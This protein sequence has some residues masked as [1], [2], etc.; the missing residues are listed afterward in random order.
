MT[1]KL[2]RVKTKKPGRSFSNKQQTSSLFEQGFA[3]Y[4]AGRLKEAEDCC[5]AALAS[6]QHH[7]DA[8]HLLG[9][10]CQQT[11]DDL[12]AII[13]IKKAISITPEKFFYHLNLGNIYFSQ[14]N[15]VKAEVCYQKALEL[16][17]N[18]IPTMIHL[19]ENLEH[20]QRNQEAIDYYQKALTIEQNNSLALSGLGNA[21]LDTGMIEDSIA[22]FRKLVKTAPDSADSYYNLGNALMRFG[23]M[24]EAAANYRKSLQLHPGF[25]NAYFNLGLALEA[26]S[27]PNQPL[28]E[29]ISFYEKA[30]TGEANHPQAL[31]G[32]GSSLLNAGMIEEAIA[33]FRKLVKAA[34]NSA[35]SYFNLGHGLMRL[36]VTEAAEQFK[37]ALQLRPDFVEALHGLGGTCEYLG[38]LDEA[39]NCYRNAIRIQP[40]FAAAHYQLAKTQKHQSRDDD[41]VAMEKLLYSKKLNPQNRMMLA[42]GLGKAYEELK[43][44]DQAF[45]LL[46]E[47][48]RLKRATF[49]FNITNEAAY[50]TQTRKD[51]GRSLFKSLANA[52]TT[53]EGAIFVLGM[54]RSGTSLVEQIL[55]SHPDVFGAGELPYLGNIRS[56]HNLASA[57]N[58]A[59]GRQLKTIPASTLDEMGHEYLA[60]TRSLSEKTETKYIVDK[61]PHNFMNIGM[62]KLILPKA[63]IIHCRRLPMDNCL[64]IYKNFFDFAHK[65]AYNMNELGKYYNLYQQLMGHWHRVLPG[66]IYDICYEDLVADQE[67]NSRALF[68]FCGIPWDSRSLDFHQ[69]KRAV[70]TLSSSQVRQPI[71]SDSVKLWEKYGEKLTELAHALNEEI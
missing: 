44:Y 13:F 16:N 45:D 32:L 23:D 63:K 38:R 68:E 20:S 41:I 60:M 71:Y 43:L 62:I 26:G 9:M 66:F 49:E 67:K 4:Q 37:K 19:A 31:T 25:V 2:R 61:M 29:A 35:E 27:E 65:Y 11:G 15:H 53:G 3:H 12:N 55:A 59:L 40:S 34:P 47:A 10:I 24:I 14:K 46:E 54:P 17:P 18:F 30:L 58:A 50:F 22:T 7:P 42:F 64:S 57:P 56:S 48:N 52:G 39:R 1:K 33:T 21:L 70:T 69:T 6:G 51:F 28:P 36:N 8:L 5:R